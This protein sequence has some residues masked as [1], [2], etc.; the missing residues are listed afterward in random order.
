[1]TK[2]DK[3]IKLSL[4]VHSLLKNHFADNFP[5]DPSKAS[6]M[7]FNEVKDK[8]LKE[9]ERIFMDMTGTLPEHIHR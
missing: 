8:S 6:K 2:D 9:L 7:A 3:R 4:R 1:M 5:I